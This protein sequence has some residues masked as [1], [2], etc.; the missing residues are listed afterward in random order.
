[1]SFHELVKERSLVRVNWVDSRI[2]SWLVHKNTVS[3]RIR[4][5]FKLT[6]FAYPIQVTSW[7]YPGMINFP[8]GGLTAM[9]GKS[10]TAAAYCIC[11]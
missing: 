5:V 2:V 6:V 11:S 9:F 1:M 10:S 3:D 4:M 8:P 7:R